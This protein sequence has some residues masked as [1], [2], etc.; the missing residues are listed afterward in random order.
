MGTT[1]EIEGHTI[2]NLPDAGFDIVER[3]IGRGL[4]QT[5]EIHGKI[6]Y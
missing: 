6:C 2:L 4:F 5:S 1:G 3:Q